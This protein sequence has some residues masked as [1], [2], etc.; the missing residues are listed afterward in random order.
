MTRNAK[1][2]TLT[3]NVYIISLDS[4]NRSVIVMGT[5]SV[6]SNLVTVSL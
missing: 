6:F 2:Q 1:G 4:V 5:V 3:V